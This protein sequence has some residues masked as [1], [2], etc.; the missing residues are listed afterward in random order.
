M[1]IKESWIKLDVDSP[2]N[3]AR[4]LGEFLQANIKGQN[5]AIKDVAEALEI[6]TA[7]FQ[8]DDKPIYRVLCM[9]PSGVGKTLLAETVS[10]FFFGNPRSFTR[11]ACEAYSEP[12]AIAKLIGSPPGYV[13]FWDTSKDGKASIP[14]LAQESI[15]KYAIES[16]DQNR[17]RL[18]LLKKL[19]EAVEHAENLIFGISERRFLENAKDKDQDEDEKSERILK[20]LLE[21]RI[22]YKLK[23]S[24]ITQ[25]LP[26]TTTQN[27]L[28]I[29]LFD[30]VEKASSTLHNILLNILEKAE[31]TLANGNVTRFNNTIII[32][33][34]NANS[35]VIA[36]LI[37]KKPKMGF[38][39]DDSEKKNIN[40][41][42]Q[43]YEK[44]M[45]AARRFFSPEFLA[46][47]DRISV[48]RPLSEAILSEIFDLELSKFEDAF[49]KPLAI[50]LDMDKTVKQFILRE[51]TDHPQNGAR[52]LKSKIYKYL[53]K[54][55][56]RLK[57]RGELTQG[58]VLHLIMDQNNRT[59]EFYKESGPPQIPT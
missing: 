21:E 56:G 29:I 34:S 36:D 12:H 59:V 28:S 54:Q 1:A 48:F 53:K 50:I 16:Q 4:R 44:S 2:G 6:R 55:L 20:R 24:E 9:G 57:N 11:I 17:K 37:S 8:E 32:M 3:S 35:K 47:F 31:L 43:I 14:I 7:G 51:A 33:T 41:D 18:A 58:T 49:L 39:A 52:L 38:R 5:D 19:N 10:R 46:R 25:R 42:A 40:I 45:D 26:A 27:P 13:G 30:E 23:I 15:D 22:K